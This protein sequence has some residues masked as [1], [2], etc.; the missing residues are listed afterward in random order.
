MRSRL[1][2]VSSGNRSDDD[3]YD[4]RQSRSVRSVWIWRG[5]LLLSLVAAG[6]TI[7]FASNG[8]T[9]FAIMWGVIT[10]G[11]FGIARYLWRLHSQV[12]EEEYGRQQA[13]K[14]RR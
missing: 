4:V 6:I 3:R 5:F 14:K 1:A 13:L 11:W 2:V 12:E 7:V 9:N 8:V 10:A